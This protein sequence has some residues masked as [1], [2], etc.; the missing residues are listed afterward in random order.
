MKRLDGWP[1][2]IT[3][4]VYANWRNFPQFV[5]KIPVKSKFNWWFIP[6]QLVA[7]AV[8]IIAN[9]SPFFLVLSSVLVFRLL[10][11]LQAIMWIIEVNLN[12]NQHHL[13]YYYNMYFF[14]SHITSHITSSPPPHHKKTATAFALGLHGIVT[15][16][17]HSFE[18]KHTKLVSWVSIRYNLIL[19]LCRIIRKM[20][21]GLCFVYQIKSFSEKWGWDDARF[22]LH[23]MMS[24][25]EMEMEMCVA[26]EQKGHSFVI[27]HFII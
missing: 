17:K 13:R 26:D 27:S 21:V 8:S 11:Q 24:R 15:Q 1:N 9:P 12:L 6:V 25:P 5:I 22:F 3:K 16:Q 19:Y 23:S 20:N 18:L 7:V 2:R 14:A 10:L 4:P